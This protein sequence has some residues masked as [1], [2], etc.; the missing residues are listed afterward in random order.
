VVGSGVNVRGCRGGM[1]MILMGRLDF[2]I[3]M[4]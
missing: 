2:C 4:R 3:D 1:S